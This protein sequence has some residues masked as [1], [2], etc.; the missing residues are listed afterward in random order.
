MIFSAWRERRWWWVPPL[1][2]LLVNLFALA[3]FQL[4]YSGV[5]RNVDQQLERRSAELA[6]VEKVLEEQRAVVDRVRA[7]EQQVESFYSSRLSTSETR[8]TDVLREVRQLAST[9]G[10]AP[11]AVDY[12]EDKLEE[13]GLEKRGISFGVEG[14]YVALRRF[15]NLLELSDSFL[16]LEDVNLSGRGEERLRIRLRLSTLFSTRG[17]DES[18]E[19]PAS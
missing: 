15:I 11:S 8:L 2:L 19:E 17:S 18:V 5:A 1:L 9:A 7:N 10:L 14:N 13:F 16:T 6:S 4:V 12:P 3:W